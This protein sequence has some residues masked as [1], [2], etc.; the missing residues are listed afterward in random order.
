KT[1]ADVREGDE[2]ATARE[3]DD[4]D[5]GSAQWG[6]AGAREREGDV[7]ARGREEILIRGKRL[8]ISAARG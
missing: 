8:T 2:S 3:M 7:M 5:P 6:S 4:D 1:G